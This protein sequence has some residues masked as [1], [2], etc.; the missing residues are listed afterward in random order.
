MPWMLD[1]NAWIRIL[2]QPGGRLEQALVSHRPDEIFLCSIVKAELWHGALRYE[3][4]EQR[5][6]VLSEIFGAF[7]SWP[8]ED[9]AAWHDAQIRHLLESAGQVIGPN[10]LK[11]AAICRACNCTLVTS[12]TDEF[13]RVPDLQIEDWS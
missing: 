1:A 11:I 5:L 13:R 12:N 9:H 3:R 10:D 6:A 7:V 4:R 8:F 2:K